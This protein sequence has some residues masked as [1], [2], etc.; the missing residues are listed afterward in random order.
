MVYSRLISIFFNLEVKSILFKE[1][2]SLFFFG[3]V[4]RILFIE[5][6]NVKRYEF[7]D[8][9]FENFLYKILNSIFFMF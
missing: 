5:N 2:C 1:M 3:V 6:V 9:L 7:E 8:R 4:Y